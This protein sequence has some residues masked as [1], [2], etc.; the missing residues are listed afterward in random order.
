MLSRKSNKGVGKWTKVL[1]KSRK[2]VKG[3]IASNSQGS[4]GDDVVV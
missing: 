3:N 2:L 1:R 4:F